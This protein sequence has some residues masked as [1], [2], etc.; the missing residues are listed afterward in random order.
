MLVLLLVERLIIHFGCFCLILHLYRRCSSKCEYFIPYV[1]KPDNSEYPEG[2]CWSAQH[3]ADGISHTFP[4]TT[5]KSCKPETYTEPKE[6]VTN[7]P[8]AWPPSSLISRYFGPLIKQSSAIAA[9]LFSLTSVIPLAILIVNYTRKLGD[10]ACLPTLVI[11]LP[12]YPKYLTPTSSTV[13]L[14]SLVL[15]I[16][17][18]VKRSVLHKRLHTTVSRGY[19]TH[20]SLRCVPKSDSRMRQFFCLSVKLSTVLTSWKHAVI[21]C[22]PMN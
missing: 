11:A 9:L 3:I 20:P 18:F 5:T 2:C 13:P 10:F 1:S 14:S 6:D 7:N 19:T 17:S 22:F 12:I 16:A 8:N 21:S 4:S 15:T